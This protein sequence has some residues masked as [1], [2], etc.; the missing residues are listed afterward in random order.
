MASPTICRHL[1]AF[2]PRARRVRGRRRGAGHGRDVERPAGRHL[3]RRRPLQP[4]QG[5]ERLR[6]R[7]RRARHRRRSHRRG[8]ARGDRR[9][10]RA[11]RSAAR[12]RTRRQGA[13]STPRC[14]SRALYWMPNAIPQLGLGPDASTPPSSPSTQQDRGLAALGGVMLRELDAFTAARRANAEHI[15]AAI[16]PTR[17]VHVPPVP[18]DC[19]PA[20]LRLPLLV[21]VPGWRD[22][23]VAA[24]TAAGIGATTSYPAALADVPE[25]R[26]SLAGDGAA[27][28]GARIA[29]SRILTLPTHPYVSAAD[30]G[31]IAAV[32]RRSCDAD[33]VPARHGSGD[34]M[35]AR[36]LRVRVTA[37]VKQALAHVL[38]GSGA[39]RP[40]RA[41][42]PAR[43]RRGPHLSSR[44]RRRGR[45]PDWSHPAIVV[46]RARS[47]ARWRRSRRHFEVL[48]LADFAERLES[49]TALRAAVVP[50]DVRRRLDRHL[51]PG[52][53]GAAR[54]GVPAMVFL[55]TWIHRRR[56]RMFW[57]ERARRC[58][59]D[60]RRGPAP[61]RRSPREPRRAGAARPRRPARGCRP[62]SCARPSSDAMQARKHERPGR[63]RSPTRRRCC[64]LASE[65]R[66][67]R[68]RRRRLHDLGP[69]PR[70]GA[71]RASRS[72]AHG[73]DPPAS[74]TRCRRRTSRPRSAR[75]RRALDRERP[76]HADRLLLPE[77]Q[78]EPECAAAV[79]AP[80]SA[81]PSRPS[82]ARSDRTAERFAIRR[83][84]MHEDVTRSVPL[85]LARLA[86]VLC[87]SWPPI[88]VSPRRPPPRRWPAPRRPRRR[89]ARWPLRSGTSAIGLRRLRAGPSLIEYGRAG[90]AT[91]PSLKRHAA[92]DAARLRP[93]RPGRRRGRIAAGHGVAAGKL[94]TRLRDLHRRSA[95]CG[96]WCAPTCRWPALPPRLLRPVHDHGLAGRLA[97]SASTCCRVR[98][99]SR[100][101]SRR[102]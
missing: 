91:F 49:R 27:C 46:R 25:L 78:L 42:A 39:A 77:R 51:R 22:K 44:P 81:S 12:C 29:A 75:S 69:G 101:W 80:A 24:L 63:A 83:V 97:A 13:S 58:C 48:S 45:R 60:R 37:A 8:H 71:G 9:A 89:R 30:I 93:V 38:Y 65:S 14:C 84:N 32:A 92:V 6:H 35:S 43:P 36:P 4:G 74:S 19:Q 54:H 3:G 96:R 34:T 68:R 85:F 56:R 79:R 50:G 41:P 61:T 53:A 94:F 87:D 100:S 10:R 33:P 70:D 26:P 23:L 57:Q 62:A 99:S 20:W 2:A 47:S 98:P 11:R 82:A 55:P 59:L 7:R 1:V 90:A 66:R 31:T 40:A 95:S 17:G 72:A 73:V 28:P 21:T 86:G 5:Q 16:G 15:L 88:A 64:A 102:T 76:G 52:L 18:A 67:R